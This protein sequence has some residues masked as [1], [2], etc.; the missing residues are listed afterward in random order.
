MCSV[1]KTVGKSVAHHL[2]QSLCCSLLTT[3]AVLAAHLQLEKSRKPT[4]VQYNTTSCVPKDPGLSAGLKKAELG[5]AAVLF[6]ACSRG[7]ALT[8]LHVFLLVCHYLL[9]G[10]DITSASIPYTEHVSQQRMIKATWPTL[11]LSGSGSNASY[12]DRLACSERPRPGN[13]KCWTWPV[14]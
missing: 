6:D 13:N 1:A 14:T 12:T 4:N 8:V 2:V 10:I 5:C 7:P 3:A 11:A 9:I